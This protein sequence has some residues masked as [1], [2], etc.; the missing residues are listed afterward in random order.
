MNPNHASFSGSWRNLRESPESPN[1]VSFHS[2]VGGRFIGNPGDVG[3]PLC[4]IGR[5]GMQKEQIRKSIQEHDRGVSFCRFVQ[6]LDRFSFGT[7]ANGSSPVKQSR[8]QGSAG[9]D[10]IL[11]GGQCRFPFMDPVGE[12]VRM[13]VADPG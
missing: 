1:D 7:P 10:E 9:N 6:K 12:L 2:S 13:L 4:L 8:I 5:S 11:E 3:N